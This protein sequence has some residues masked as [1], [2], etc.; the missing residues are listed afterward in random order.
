M[1]LQK[2]S[3]FSSKWA[4]CQGYIVKRKR[5]WNTSCILNFSWQ[6]CPKVAVGPNPPPPPKKLK[7]MQIYSKTFSRSRRNFL[8]GNF[9]PRGLTSGL[10]ETAA[11]LH[12]QPWFGDVSCPALSHRHLFPPGR[13]TCP[14]SI[15]LPRTASDVI[16][17]LWSGAADFSFFG[18]RLLFFT[19]K[20]AQS[21]KLLHCLW[22]WWDTCLF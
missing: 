7:S 9:P 11:G 21:L 18:G 3:C 16:P 2:K 8:G 15:H 20:S 14:S 22:L 4:F 17:P 6:V 19:C 12:S 5:T 10:L 1:Q 13:D